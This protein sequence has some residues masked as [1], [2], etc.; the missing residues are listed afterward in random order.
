[1][2]KIKYKLL[3]LMVL[4]SSSLIAGENQPF[5]K[6]E[7]MHNRKWQFL[8]VKS[9]LSPKEIEAVYPIF[10][11]YEKTMWN[12]HTKNRDF[13]QSLRNMQGDQ[14]LNYSEINDRYAEIELTQ[15][16]LFKAYHLKLRKVLSPETLFKY[17]R[18]EREFK[19]N[20][21]QNIPNHR[22]H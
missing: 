6:V 16:Q 3:F 11:E 22:E 13:F 20:L 10:M 21:L 19:R 1:M 5:P 2:K 8:T 4:V 15:A 14:K 7:E 9:E 12:F 18:A 17:Y